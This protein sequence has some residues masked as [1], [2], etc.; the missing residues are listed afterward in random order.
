MWSIVIVMITAAFSD[1]VSASGSK[2]AWKY[3]S[4]V[5]W[6]KI[7][8]TCN[9]RS[10]SPVN[11]DTR[12][13]K[14]DDNMSLK[15]TGY[16]RQIPGSNFSVVNNGHTVVY[17]LE[18]ANMDG[19]KIPRLQGTAFGGEKYKFVQLHFHWNTE[20]HTNG[21]EHAI[22]GRRYALELHLV[23]IN[24]KYSDV[25][26]AV[27]K[28]G[29]IVVLGILFQI[30]RKNNSYLTPLI[31]ANSLVQEVGMN[32]T[33]FGK[34]IT[35]DHLLPNDLDHFF[36]YSGSLTTPPCSEPVTWIVFR[37]ISGISEDQMRS[38]RSLMSDE[39]DELDESKKLPMS[40]N[41]RDLQRIRKRDI[42][43]SGSQSA[44]QSSALAIHAYV[45]SLPL[46]LPITA[47][48]IAIFKV[49]FL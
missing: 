48:I 23:H 2:V 19:D 1:T 25:S 3:S 12:K 37:E 36:K 32:D 38:F 42:I 46:I 4:Q 28:D 44:S 14:Y 17:K 49:S 16:D 5:L 26:D 35:L 9:G 10:Q 34:Q 8:P 21:S 15:F 31:E 47:S 13:V 6:P 40:D 43:A 7:A 20:R 27:G 11:I 41:V 39:V 30:T 22:D 24:L 45:P 29:A 33:L 18:T